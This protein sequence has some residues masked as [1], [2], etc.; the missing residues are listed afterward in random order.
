MVYAVA[1]EDHRYLRKRS[2]ASRSGRPRE[3]VVP[4]ES[5]LL[6]LKNAGRG[7]PK[8]T[9]DTYQRLRTY[10]HALRA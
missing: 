5:R 8:T 1:I 3:I 2:A 7:G 10:P 6:K 4:Q 9:E